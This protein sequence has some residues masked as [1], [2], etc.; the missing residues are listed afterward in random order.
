MLRFYSWHFFLLMTNVHLDKHRATIDSKN[1]R[2][3][4]CAEKHAFRIWI[5]FPDDWGNVRK[6]FTAELRQF[7]F[8]AH[9][10]FSL[11]PTKR[12]SLCIHKVDERNVVAGGE[13]EWKHRR[14]CWCCVSCLRR[15]CCYFTWVLL[16]CDGMLLCSIAL[17]SLV[18]WKSNMIL[19]IFSYAHQ[20]PWSCKF[21]N[22][23]TGK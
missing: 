5:S 1:R 22:K 14:F 6:F 7:R 8:R 9:S 19:T 11:P 13:N 10:V 4:E 23:S 20:S 15:I 2:E 16:N 12:F 21:E 3:H 17:F 18:S